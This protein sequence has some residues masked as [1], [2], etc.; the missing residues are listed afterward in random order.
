MNS[1]NDIILY[2]LI[3][4]KK[5]IDIKAE[6]KD[7]LLNTTFFSK[8]K[9]LKKLGEGSFGKVYKAI[10]NNEYFALKMEEASLEHNLL[11]KESTILQY[12]Q[13]GFNIPKFE[14]YGYC[15]EHNIL[16]MQLLD[17]S[18]DDFLNKLKTFSIKTTAMI[19]YQM[20][21]ILQK[22]HDKHIIHRDV[23]PD[24]FAMGR[25][26]YNAILYIIDFGLAKKFRSSK[27]L[28]QLPLTKRKS[29][30]GTARYASINALQGYE[31]SRRDDLESVGYSLMY[32]LR[33][34]LPWQN[35]KI[36][37]KKDKYNKIL[38]KKKDLSSKELG[39]DFPIEFAEILDYF[40]NLGYTDDPDYEMCKRKLLKI[41][42]KQKLKFDYIYDWTTF[43]N[44]KDRNKLKKNKTLQR[45]LSINVLNIEEENKN[46]HDIKTYIIE[47]NESE[48][49]ED[50]D[51][52]SEKMKIEDLDENKNKSDSVSESESN[53]SN[54][55][56]IDEFDS[57]GLNPKNETECCL[58]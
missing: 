48:E 44:L 3:H 56:D 45:M 51:N 10:Y 16:V 32:F 8:Y 36:K 47:E 18:L 17:K 27:T 20:I 7:P 53:I 21:N 9:T 6:E 37:N 4:K 12:L 57:P 54:K 30:T 26:E 33:G 29:L 5:S 25:K 19:G 41:I 38:N 14:K 24:N 15:K 40:K 23:K 2:S 22:I 43:T 55:A 31:Q 1:K 39:K 58:M 28:K 49:E 50:E 13:E 35:I 46:N 11:E 52:N 42:Q 34:N